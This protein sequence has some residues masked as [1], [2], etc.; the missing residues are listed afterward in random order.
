MSHVISIEATTGTNYVVDLRRTDQVGTAPT[1]PFYKACKLRISA[2]QD[3]GAAAKAIVAPIIVADDAAPPSPAALT[4]TST[5]KS[6]TWLDSTLH[7]YVEIGQSYGPGYS[8]NVFREIVATH[9]M[10]TPS[11]TGVIEIVVD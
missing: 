2:V 7:P 1:G 5:P 8:P 3:G 11:A 4:I 6:A 10:I 9:V